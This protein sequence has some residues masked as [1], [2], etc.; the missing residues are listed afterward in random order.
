MGVTRTL[1]VTLLRSK[2]MRSVLVSMSVTVLMVI[3]GVVLVSAARSSHSQ[4]ISV[5]VYPDAKLL[6]KQA[7]DQSDRRVYSTADSVDQV[8]AF[9][10]Q[11]LN[12]DDGNG[13]KKIYTD[14]PPSDDPGH[15][16]GSCIVDTS[17]MDVSQRLAIRVNYA[18]GSGTLIEVERNWGG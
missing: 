7:D 17:W 14:T 3:F 4:P 6:E 18:A 12:E 10:A 11:R 5:E 8:L 15:Y 16:I 1:A 13:C 2:L 9:Y